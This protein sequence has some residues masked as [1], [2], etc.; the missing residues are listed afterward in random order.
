VGNQRRS[1]KSLS[2]SS[3]LSPDRIHSGVA[4]ECVSLTGTRTRPYSSPFPF[5]Q[6]GR[7]LREGERQLLTV[8]AGEC[9]GS[10]L[11]LRIEAD[12]K[13]EPAKTIPPPSIT[14]KGGGNGNM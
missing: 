2:P 4:S 5:R 3:S 14:R 12:K 6:L 13:E 9:V 11:M 10:I 1:K 7:P 8:L